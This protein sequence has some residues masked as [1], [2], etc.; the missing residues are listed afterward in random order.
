[1]R[2]AIIKHDGTWREENI[3]QWW[4]GAGHTS[5]TYSH[6]VRFFAQEKISFD[7]QLELS[8]VPLQ[9]NHANAGL[10]QPSVSLDCTD[11]AIMQGK[12]NLFWARVKSRLNVLHVPPV[13]SVSIYL[14]IFFFLTA[15]QTDG[16]P[17]T[18]NRVIV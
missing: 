8:A 5:T 6:T 3:W 2:C 11:Y 15:R 7:L 18:G 12:M 16:L 4:T 9:I 14:F 17:G 13:P 10:S 1:M